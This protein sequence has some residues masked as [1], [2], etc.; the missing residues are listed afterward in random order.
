MTNIQDVPC[1]PE[2]EKSVLCS[3]LLEPELFDKA[4]ARGIS[5][6]SFSEKR[7]IAIWQAMASISAK[8]D[9]IDMM[10]LVDTLKDKAAIFNNDP[11]SFIMELMSSTATTVAYSSWLG[12]LKTHQ[13]NRLALTSA[14]EIIKAVKQHTPISEITK[15]LECSIAEIRNTI[16]VKER[17]STRQLLKNILATGLEKPE[18]PMLCGIRGLEEKLKIKRKKLM[19]LAAAPGT[20]KTGF[21]LNDM[22]GRAMRGEKVALFCGETASQDIM[23]R[24]IAIESGVKTDV[25]EDLTSATTSEFAAIQKAC[26]RIKEYESNFFILGKGDYKH[27]PLG[28]KTELKK[29]QEENDNKIGLVYLDYLQNLRP[30]GRNS[31]MGRVEQ[32]ESDILDVNDTLGQL[33]VAGIVLCQLNRDKERVAK[34]LRPSI[35]DLKGS[36]AIEQE[37]DYIIFLH[38]KKEKD[39]AKYGDVNIEIFSEKIRGASFLDEV[40]VYNTFSGR[41]MTQ[42]YFHKYKKEDCKI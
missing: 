25:I 14:T 31:K 19:I 10:I 26:M 39:D 20:G 18:P 13:A 24:L 27:S 12:A 7:H 36:S 42:E 3:I 2:I 29:L 41:Y 4:V 6:L 1:A 8:G 32:I 33:N 15:N 11:M 35:Y 23:A 38:R 40:L 22:R 17:I 9:I 16:D 34:G 28:F 5:Q 30:D 21:C 37:A